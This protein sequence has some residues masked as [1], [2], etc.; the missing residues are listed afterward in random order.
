VTAPFGRRL[1]A[2]VAAREV[3]ARE[4]VRAHLDRIAAVGPRVNAVVALDEERALARAGEL[5][6]ADARAG[7][8]HGVPFTV[9]DT[10]AVAGLPMSV[11]DPA[12]AGVVA[13]ETPRW[14]P[15]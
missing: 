2:A 8:L 9:K 1:A 6:R 12:R 15:G 7:P 10:I 4:V 14:S 11:G 5:D 13:G 3:S